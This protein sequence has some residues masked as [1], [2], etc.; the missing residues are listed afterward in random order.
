MTG[1]IINILTVLVGGTTGLLFGARLPER[2]RETVIAGLGLF[3]AA[4]GIQ[5][6]LNGLVLK[7]LR[8]FLLMQI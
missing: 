5:M 6:F 8:E 3:T 1:T 4:L 2:V 7:E